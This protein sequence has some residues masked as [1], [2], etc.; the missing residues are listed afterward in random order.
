ME[1]GCE[2]LTPNPDLAFKQVAMYTDG[3]KTFED[4]GGDERIKSPG[5]IEDGISHNASLPV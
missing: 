5:K 3:E 2:G 1:E 4:L